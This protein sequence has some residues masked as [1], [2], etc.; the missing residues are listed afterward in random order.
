MDRA[1]L[2]L[3]QI[4]SVFCERL[5]RSKERARTV[6]QAHGDG[7]FTGVL[8]GWL[9]VP[10]GTQQDK[11][12]K[13][14]RIIL[15]AR[16][17]D[18]AAVVLRGAAAG[19]SRATAIAVR[20]H[21]TNAS[22]G[23]FRGNTLQVRMSH[24]ESLALRECHWMRSDRPQT[25]ERRAATTDQMVLDRQDRL[26]GNREGALQKQIVNADNRPGE[27]IF[28]RSQDRIRETVINGPESRIKCGAW[29]RSDSV[30]EK[31]DGGFFTESAG[32]ALK[33]DT[34]R[35]D[36]SISRNADDGCGIRGRFARI[37]S[38]RDETVVQGRR[39][40]E[41][42]KRRASHGILRWGEER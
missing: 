21:V 37:E 24:K 22:G 13:V 28:D 3:Q 26:G 33:R 2:D 35:M 19:N 7:H 15:N 31:L 39:A 8:R 4:N 20:D 10:R 32:F 29:N 41:A 1:A 12:G 16:G 42:G 27:G 17:E 30:S 38:P 11:A 40:P 34:H 18:V 25:S 36:D 6:R 9:G 14:L 23:I 5:E